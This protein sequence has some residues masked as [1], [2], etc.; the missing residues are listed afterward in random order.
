MMGSAVLRTPVAI[1]RRALGLDKT[2]P[3]TTHL[4][5]WCGKPAIIQTYRTLYEG[6]EYEQT[7]SYF[8]CVKCMSLPNNRV[9]LDS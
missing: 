8:E 9:G 4:C 6:T 2:A 5:D 7:S 1:I 3:R